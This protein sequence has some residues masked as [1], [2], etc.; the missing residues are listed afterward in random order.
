M[1]EIITLIV[2]GTTILLVLVFTLLFLRNSRKKK[3]SA[4]EIDLSVFEDR[5]MELVSKF[6]HISATRLSSLE[7]K[8]NEVNALL[9]EANETYLKLSSILSDATKVLTE[10]ERKAGEKSVPGTK[11]APKK[12][13]PFSDDAVGTS[14]VVIIDP[15]KDFTSVG[16]S[17]KKMISEDDGIFSELPVSP[18]SKVELTVKVKESEDKASVRTDEKAFDLKNSSLEHKILNL[19]SEGLECGD[20]AKKLGVG[21]GEVELVLGLFKRKFI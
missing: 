4:D 21:K 15:R 1:P 2:T 14:D 18:P 8:I 9:K 16:N 17:K 6:Q 3:G 20:I 19:S 7:N 13:H 5:V 11:E 12:E 10:L